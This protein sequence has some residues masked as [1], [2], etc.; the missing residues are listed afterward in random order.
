MIL[1]SC[2]TSQSYLQ[3]TET[4]VEAALDS[5][6]AYHCLYILSYND[7]KVDSPLY[8][9]RDERCS[10]SMEYSAIQSSVMNGDQWTRMHCIGVRRSSVIA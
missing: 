5:Y 10:K 1:M 7:R 4:M 8:S 2:R 9:Y 6:E 3:C